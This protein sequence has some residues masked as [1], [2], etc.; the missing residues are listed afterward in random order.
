MCPRAAA[1]ALLQS[2]LIADFNQR[3]TVTPASGNDAHRPVGREHNLAAILSLQYERVVTNDYVVRFENR[4]Y[5]IHKPAHPGLRKG[6]VI[7]ELRLDGTMAI[8]FG[9]KYLK[10]HEITAG[11]EALG[12]SAPQTPE[13]YRI[14]GRRQV[15]RKRA[16]PRVRRASP[17]AYSRPT[18]IRSHF[19]GALSSRRRRGRYQ[20]GAV[21]SSRESPLAKE[22]QGV[23]TAG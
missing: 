10:Y 21:P 19:C 6:R 3:F 8:R 17:L 23:V 22:L 9:D 15:G 2:S 7:I 5:Q 1:N 12:G 20:E 11:G 18:G 13:V 4:F 16:S 14:H